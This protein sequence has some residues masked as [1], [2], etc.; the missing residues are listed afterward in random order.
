MLICQRANRNT[1][2]SHPTTKLK[3]NGPTFVAVVVYHDDLSQV[4]PG[5]P[6][7]DTVD[8]SHECRPALIM[9]DY[10]HTGGQQSVII[11]PV[12]TP[13]EETECHC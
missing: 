1:L 11:M 6:L 9:E 2:Q 10:H 5:S 13:G 3:E 8:G 12:L 4:S 7:N